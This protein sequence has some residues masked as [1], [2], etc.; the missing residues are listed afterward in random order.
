MS[1]LKCP[2]CSSTILIETK[3]DLVSLHFDLNCKR[4]C[5]LYFLSFDD[6]SFIL[7]TRTFSKNKNRIY[8]YSSGLYDISGGESSHFSYN[9]KDIDI[10]FYFPKA[11]I[12]D[13]LPIVFE[14]IS[15]TINNQHLI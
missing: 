15:L 11:N 6:G 9:D 2:I 10:N 5:T 14:I 4:N 7:K 3:K 1:N 8:F 12:L 13:S